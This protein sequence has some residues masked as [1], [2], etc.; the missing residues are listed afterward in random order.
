M[1]VATFSVVRSLGRIDL[2]DDFVGSF[3]RPSNGPSAQDDHG[4][5]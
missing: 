5:G 1:K 3:G 2:K 4:C